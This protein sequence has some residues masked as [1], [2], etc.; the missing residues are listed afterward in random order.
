MFS[1]E[2]GLLRLAHDLFVIEFFR[3]QLLQR[4]HLCLGPTSALCFSLR[5]AMAPVEEEWQRRTQNQEISSGEIAVRLKCLKLG[6]EV[7]WRALKG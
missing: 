7:V 6:V 2:K 4:L 1:R 5:P 3:I